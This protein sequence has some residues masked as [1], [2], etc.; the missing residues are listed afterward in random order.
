MVCG[1]IGAF[2]LM[3]PMCGHENLLIGMA[4]DDTW[5]KKMAISYAETTI[6]LLETLFRSRRIAGRALGM[7]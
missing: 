5:V 6:R 2:D 7:G 4:L 1:V 3:A